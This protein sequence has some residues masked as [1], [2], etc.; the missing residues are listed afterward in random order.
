ML[1]PKIDSYLFLLSQR[2]HRADRC[3]S[4]MVLM[5]L[6]HNRKMTEINSNWMKTFSVSIRLW[7]LVKSL[8]WPFRIPRI[9]IYC[10]SDFKWKKTTGAHIRYV[11]SA[12]GSHRAAFCLPSASSSILT[13]LE[14]LGEL[15][16][17][18]PWVVP[19]PVDGQSD[20]KHLL[21][22]VWSLKTPSLCSST[23]AAR[24]NWWR[25]L[26]IWGQR[27]APA[28]PPITPTLYKKAQQHLHLQTNLR[29]SSITCTSLLEC[30]L[31]TESMDPPRPLH[32]PL[33]LLQWGRRYKI[34]LAHKNIYE[35]PFIHAPAGM[36]TVHCSL[37]LSLDVCQRRTSATLWDRL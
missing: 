18:N 27:W 21:K 19:T 8:T 35:K 30:R 15:P 23:L 26:N 10:P 36:W 34:P 7:A 13:S 4:V 32:D 2:I 28:C 25:A 1:E 16:V 11:D 24:V 6:L 12:Q 14:A 29:T 31:T 3:N 17:E 22:T 9:P 5:S 20:S 33:M 37:L